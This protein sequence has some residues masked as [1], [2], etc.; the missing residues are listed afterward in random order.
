M[1]AVGL[2]GCCAVAREVFHLGKGGSTSRVAVQARSSGDPLQLNASGAAAL[3]LLVLRAGCMATSGADERAIYVRY[4]RLELFSRNAIRTAHNLV[5]N[6]LLQVASG[7]D[8][9][10]ACLF[11]G[12]GLR[13][14]AVFQLHDCS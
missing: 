11:A 8:G 5:H 9:V 10:A 2:A 14:I 12:V 3:V 4:H 13:V 6:L 1:V 7:P